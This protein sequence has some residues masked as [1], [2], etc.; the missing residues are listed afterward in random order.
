MSQ[1]SVEILL[2]KLLTDEGFRRSFFPARTSTA[3][4]PDFAAAE[5]RCLELTPIERS[6]L[7]T[8]RRHRFDLMAES[9]DPRISRSCGSAGAECPEEPAVDG[10]RTHLLER[11]APKPNNTRTLDTRPMV[12]EDGRS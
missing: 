6:A 1:R 4:T 7:S 8:L 2:G 9:L 5:S 10:G 3:R 12:K 11:T